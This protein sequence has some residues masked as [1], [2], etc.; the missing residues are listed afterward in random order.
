ML[1]DLYILSYQTGWLLLLLLLLLA[2]ALY[3]L[4]FFLSEIW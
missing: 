4:V 2:L 3:G 1:A